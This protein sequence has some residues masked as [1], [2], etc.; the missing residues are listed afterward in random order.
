MTLPHLAVSRYRLQKASSVAKLK[1]AVRRCGSTPLRQYAATVFSTVSRHASAVGAIMVSNGRVQARPRDTAEAKKS[2]GLCETPSAIAT[3]SSAPGEGMCLKILHPPPCFFALSLM[4]KGERA[5]FACSLVVRD[6]F[7]PY[8]K[9]PSGNCQ[10]S[11]DISTVFAPS[12]SRQQ[13]DFL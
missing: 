5:S 8:L 11:T 10:V 4:Q 2:Q 9:S 13:M 3:A 1:A 12:S 6:W 7:P